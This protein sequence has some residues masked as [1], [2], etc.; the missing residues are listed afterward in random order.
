MADDVGDLGL[1]QAFFADRGGQPL[2][3]AGVL[4]R[5]LEFLPS[6][7]VLAER[8]AAGRG[9]STPEF[10]ILLSYTKIALAD[11]RPIS[12]SST[13][14]PRKAR[15]RAARSRSRPIDVHTSA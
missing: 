3:Q 14:N 13:M 10:A 2:E 1:G 4:N 8:K 15:S 6:D 5:E 11:A 12:R 7:E 9:L